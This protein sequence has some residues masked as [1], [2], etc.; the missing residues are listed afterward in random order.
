MADGSL[1]IGNRLVGGT[2]LQIFL[3]WGSVGKLYR[4]AFSA[5]FAG[6]GEEIFE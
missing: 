5:G 4:L 1:D 3:L 6:S 2:V